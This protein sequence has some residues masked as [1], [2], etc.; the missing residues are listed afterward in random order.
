M[1]DKE[2]ES[3]LKLIAADCNPK[4]KGGWVRLEGAVNNEAQMQQMDAAFQYIEEH[5]RPPTTY[6]W[7]ALEKPC[8]LAINNIITEQTEDCQHGKIGDAWKP[9]VKGVST[10]TEIDRENGIVTFDSE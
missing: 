3:K 4:V 2:L 10:V 7:P 6:S 9:E 8:H 1:D 5:P